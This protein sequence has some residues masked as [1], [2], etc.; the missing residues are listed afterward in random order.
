MPYLSQTARKN[1]KLYA[2]KAVDEYVYP[3]P[4]QPLILTTPQVSCIPTRP[5]SLLELVHHSVAAD[6][7]AEH[8]TLPI[9]SFSIGGADIQRR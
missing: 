8:S 9:Q 1:L 5:C 4:H 7:R 3:S 6:G 2:Y